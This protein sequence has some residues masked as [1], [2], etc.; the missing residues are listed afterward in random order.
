MAIQKGDILRATHGVLNNQPIIYVYVKNKDVLDKLKDIP[1]VIK[2]GSDPNEDLWLVIPKT[3]SLKDFV[4]KADAPI[5][6]SFF[7]T[8]EAKY[9]IVAKYSVQADDGPPRFLSDLA[10]DVLRVRGDNLMGISKTFA[11][12]VEHLARLTPKWKDRDSDIKDSWHMGYAPLQ[13]D[14]SFEQKTIPLDSV[15]KTAFQHP[16]ITLWLDKMLD[17]N[18]RQ[19]VNKA[20][21]QVKKMA[22]RK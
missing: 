14:G 8:V 5:A 16:I 2:T 11:K 9:Q 3:I 10:D 4:K 18:G 12:A 19:D 20:R 17:M 7:A 13:H 21:I 1:D 15:M 22:E 6:A